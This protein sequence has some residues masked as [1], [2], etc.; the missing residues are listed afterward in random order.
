MRIVNV[1]FD[2]LDTKAKDELKTQCQS[3]FAKSAGVDNSKVAV[4]L[5][6]GS[7]KV[8]TKITGIKTSQ[9]AKLEESTAKKEL[10]SKILSV[11]KNVEGVMAAATGDISVSEPSVKVQTTT[12]TDQGDDEADPIAT[13]DDEDE[14]T[15]ESITLIIAVASSFSVCLIAAVTGLLVHRH[16]KQKKFMTGEPLSDTGDQMVRG[17]P[18]DTDAGGLPPGDNMV[19]Q[20]VVGRPTD[21][22]V[23]HDE[24]AQ[25]RKNQA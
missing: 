5:S 10:Q 14:D 13:A 9:A 2:K 24:K 19:P 12:T 1:D 22:L 20:M 18:V 15:I 3:A 8:D 23:N 4:T 7:V 17:R 21:T 6:K 16:R 11:A 25:V